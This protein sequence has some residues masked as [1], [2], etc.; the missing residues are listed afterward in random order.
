MPRRLLFT[1]LLSVVAWARTTAQCL[2]P[3]VPVRPIHFGATGGG[4][5][6][7]RHNGLTTGVWAEWKTHPRYQLGTELLYA[8]LTGAGD[9]GINLRHTHLGALATAQLKVGIFYLQAGPFVARPLRVTTR[10]KAAHLLAPGRRAGVRP[11]ES[12]VP[13]AGAVGALVLV[14]DPLRVG[15]R[16]WHPHAAWLPPFFSLYLSVRIF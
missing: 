16:Y 10:A 4:L 15:L 2:R 12:N 7:P 8:R 6:S 13:A 9:D 11:P 5:W 3:E 14:S 1:V